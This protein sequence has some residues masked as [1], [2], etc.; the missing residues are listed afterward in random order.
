MKKEKQKFYISD[1]GTQFYKCYDLDSINIE[2][3]E[4]ITKIC[5]YTFNAPSMFR[6]EDSNVEEILLPNTLVHI[7]P[8]AF[9]DCRHLTRVI[10]PSSVKY[11]SG[12]RGCISLME[13]KIPSSVQILGTSAFSSCVHINHFEIPNS[14]TKIEDSVFASCYS[15]ESIYFSDNIIELGDS[16]CWHCHHL[17]EIRLP[18]GL[19]KIN[20]FSFCDCY[21]LN[22]IVIPDTVETIGSSSFSDTAISQICLPPNLKK[23]ENSAFSHTKLIE[24]NLPNSLEY[25]SGFNECYYLQYLTIPSNVTTLGD[26]AFRSCYSLLNVDIPDGVNIIKQQAFKN[27]IQLRTLSLPKSIKLIERYAFCECPNLESISLLLDNPND[28]EIYSDTFN[29]TENKVILYVVD[30]SVDLFK[31]DSR[32]EKFQIK[33]LSTISHTQYVPFTHIEIENYVSKDDFWEKE[34]RKYM[35]EEYKRLKDGYIKIKELP[36]IQRESVV[37]LDDYNYSCNKYNCDS[38]FIFN[39]EEEKKNY[40]EHIMKI[41]QEQDYLYKHKWYFK[42]SQYLVNIPSIESFCKQERMSICFD[43]EVVMDYLSYKTL[44]PKT[45]YDD[46]RISLEQICLVGTPLI[47]GILTP[48]IILVLH[49]FGVDSCFLEFILEWFG[50]SGIAIIIGMLVY[51][52]TYGIISYKKNKSKKIPEKIGLINPILEKYT[53]K[54]G[55]HISYLKCI[56]E[57]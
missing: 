17:K 42:T 24:I 5:K 53:R 52:I 51:G 57:R 11:L 8:D 4:G 47:S 38:E 34:V 1:D 37:S 55:A 35:I 43:K 18:K 54:L 49:D 31:S 22:N 15:I 50:V 33:A 9:Y 25:L 10:I 26:Y 7:E 32:F 46:N 14:V 28:I 21:E 16:V 40:I 12:F 48:L 39:T 20:S 23:I 36:N 56:A 45:I 13:I 44:S 19:K 29:F 27:C 41:F 30:E 3:P 6:H 2:I